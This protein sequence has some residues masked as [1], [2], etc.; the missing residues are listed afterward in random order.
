MNNIH[1][2]VH[3]VFIFLLMSAESIVTF[4]LLFL[5]S[6]LCVLASFLYQFCQW[7]VNFIDIFQKT[8]FSSMDFLYS[9]SLF[10]FINFCSLLCS[11]FFLFWV[12]FA[13]FPWVVEE[14]TQITDL[15]F[16]LFSNVY[17]QC[18]KS[19]S[20]HC[21]ICDLQIF[22]C[23]IFISAQFNVFNYFP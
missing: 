22:I 1:S 20:H 5:I 9:F 18:Y 11:S 12:H 10:G 19:P 14:R 7:A 21:F 3:S 17:I 23:C 4:P 16:F 8:A 15:K 6:V 13:F 2:T